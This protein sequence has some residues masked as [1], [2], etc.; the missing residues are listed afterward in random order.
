MKAGF[1]GEFHDRRHIP[2]SKIRLFRCTKYL[3]L[4]FDCSPERTST[5]LLT[6]SAASDEGRYAGESTR[7]TD[8][9][10]RVS[11]GAAQSCCDGLR[12]DDA[13]CHLLTLRRPAG[14]RRIRGR[15]LQ[16]PRF[17]EVVKG[18]LT[19]EP[20]FRSAPTASINPKTVRPSLTGTQVPCES[21]SPE[22]RWTAAKTQPVSRIRSSPCFAARSGANF[23]FDKDTGK[24]M[25]SV[26]FIVQKF[27]RW[28]RG[29]D[30]ANF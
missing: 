28:I 11:A 10:D 8:Q 22:E 4:K 3:M 1:E 17:A 12:G 7:Q 27:A 13:R 18:W 30:G 23:G 9:C 21:L 29:E 26:S 20:G 19:R 14:E 2:N 5:T 16:R 25:I 15:M 24:L 6:L